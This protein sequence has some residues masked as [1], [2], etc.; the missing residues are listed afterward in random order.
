MK[1][2]LSKVRVYML[3]EEIHYN[4]TLKKDQ[5]QQ[6]HNISQEVKHWKN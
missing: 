6:F 1:G 5:T 3:Y 2:K 4:F